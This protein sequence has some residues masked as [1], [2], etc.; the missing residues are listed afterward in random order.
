MRHTEPHPLAGQTVLI[1]NDADEIGGEE[2]VVEDYWDR[3][4][5][6]SWM[7]SDGNPACIHYAMRI[8]FQEKQVPTDDEV[9]Y[10]KVGFF[11]KLVHVSEI[12]I[13]D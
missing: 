12:V 3:I 11:G 7:I 6:K 4:T 8:G 1:S 10:G 2:F 5:G 9:L 13:P